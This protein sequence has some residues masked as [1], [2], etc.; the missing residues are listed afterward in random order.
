[1]QH[2]ELLEKLFDKR[3]I[4]ILNVL[5]ND[6]SEEGLYLREISKLSKVSAAT[7]Y[8]ILQKLKALQVIREIRIKKSKFYKSIR[9][10]RTEFLF[11]ML[12]KD[13][14][15]L[16][17][18]IEQIKEIREIQTA[19]LHGEQTAK[20]AN[21]LL[22]GQ[23]IDTGRIKEICGSI[24]DKYHFTVSPLILTPEQ[25]EQMSSMGLYSGNEK[26]IWK[27]K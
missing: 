12:K 20:R 4:A 6:N 5:I 21:L 2:Q 8:R 26:I 3:I 14:Q 10:R 11:Q 1:M 15:V 19:I 9:S 24:L 25:Y 27:R 22:I 13:I 18:F 16:Q 17:I 7:T 23:H